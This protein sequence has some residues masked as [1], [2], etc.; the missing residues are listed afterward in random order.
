MSELMRGDPADA[1]GPGGLR[2]GAVDPV[3]TDPVSVFDEQV[4]A[5]Q[6]SR[7]GGEPGVEQVFQLRVQRDVAVAAELPDRH[8]QPV[9]GPDLHHRIG[10]EVE[11]FALAEPGAGEKFHGEP[12]E[13]VIVGAGGLEQLGERGIVEEAWQR[14]IPDGQVTGEDQYPRGDV[15]AV[16]FGEPFEAGAQNAQVFGEADRRQ[17]PAASRWPAC[18]LQFVGLDMGSAQV[19][20]PTN[21]GSILRQPA[22]ELPQHA[23]DADH[24]GG[25]QRQPGLGDVVEQGRGEHGRDAGPGRGPR[26][27]LVRGL[28]AGRRVE[29]PCVEEHRVG[30]EQRTGQVRRAGSCWSVLTD[31]RDERG[32]AGTHRLGGDLFRGK[33]NQ[34]SHFDQS[35]PLQPT[36]PWGEAE[37]GGGR[38]EPLMEHPVVAGSDLAQVGLAEHQVV[39]AGS[40]PAGDHQPA[41][42]PAVLQR[43]RALLGRRQLVPAVHADP[44]QKRAGR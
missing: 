19:G 16:P 18:E 1:G 2:D 15:V 44:G 33:T 26:F 39:R 31:R 41:G 28:P 35:G 40:E 29:H 6:G 7:A 13:R 32:T 38:D 25:P 42:H 14:F 8:V 11:E 37:L 30:A 9:G 36:D 24:R 12:D 27:R 10:G 23:L 3:L 43:C 5:S 21:L 20:D 4:A 22:G 34:H 17:G